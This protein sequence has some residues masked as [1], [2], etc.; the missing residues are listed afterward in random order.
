M[1]PWLRLRRVGQDQKFKSL[2][3]KAN[4]T[5]P[6]LPPCAGTLTWGNLS[7]GK[8]ARGRLP[9]A[10]AP[11]NSALWRNKPS[12][13]GKA[14]IGGRHGGPLPWTWLD[15][16]PLPWTWLAFC[17]GA[18]LVSARSPFRRPARQ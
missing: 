8:A 5:K 10:A 15:A 17:E 16:G 9:L 13:W 14:G 12:L 6:R 1:L 4:N 3:R 18:M 7:N 2:K 11:E